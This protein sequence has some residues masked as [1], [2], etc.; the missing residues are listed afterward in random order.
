MKTAR[1]H[2]DFDTSST[3]YTSKFEVTARCL[4]VPA[5]AWLLLPLLVAVQLSNTVILLFHSS[6]IF[7]HSL[8]MCQCDDSSQLRSAHTPVIKKDLCLKLNFKDFYETTLF[9]TL[10][11]CR[12][13]YGVVWCASFNKLIRLYDSV[14]NDCNTDKNTMNSDDICLNIDTSAAVPRPKLQ[15]QSKLERVRIFK[16]LFHM[17][18]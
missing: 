6:A 2:L 18:I 7:W 11:S 13:D 9:C 15:K 3:S 17:I 16:V 12:C 4:L 5:I 14:V 10:V 8:L 1:C